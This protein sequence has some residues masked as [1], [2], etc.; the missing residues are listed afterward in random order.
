MKKLLL[1][2]ILAAKGFTLNFVEPPE[3]W[4]S[5]KE[6]LAPVIVGSDPDYSQVIVEECTPEKFEDALNEMRNFMMRDDIVDLYNLKHYMSG[7]WFLLCE[8]RTSAHY[9]SMDRYSEK[10]SLKCLATD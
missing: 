4:T 3:N 9:V 8:G 1:I 6:Y 7:D 10:H 2:L 5:C